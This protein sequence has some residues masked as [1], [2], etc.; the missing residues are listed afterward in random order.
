MRDHFDA[1]L[2]NNIPEIQ[3]ITGASLEAIEEAIQQEI[4]HLDLRPGAW[5][6]K[7]DVQFIT[8]DISIVEDGEK[9]SIRV[10][11]EY[12]PTLRINRKYLKMMDD[13][14]LSADEKQYIKKNVLSA[15][16]LS[17]N[18]YQRNE[19]L[20]KIVET[21]L[22]RQKEFF[23]EP[24]G[25]L[26]PMI[27][28]EVSEEIDVHEST[29]ARAVANKYVDTPRG[30]FPLRYFF[31][32]SYVTNQGEELSSQTVKDAISILINKEDKKKPFSD[33]KIS[34]VLKEQGIPCARRT[35]AKY[36][37]QLN[38]GNAHQRRKYS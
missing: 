16:W 26:N 10:N 1:L 28:K 3:K 6:L 15:K 11:D 21:I 33:E 20:Y 36:R 14:N 27:M 4:A 29:V 34:K 32:H 37:D 12:V 31:T 38:L 13:P 23:T 8:P 7:Q 24:D 35:V 30:T 5:Y 9:L 25:K 22:D 19:T 18:I 17:R 2:H